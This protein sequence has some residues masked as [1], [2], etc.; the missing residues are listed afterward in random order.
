MSKG[1]VVPA[2]DLPWGA[3][4]GDH[5]H[6]LVFPDVWS[7]D[8]L[9][10]AGLAPCVPCAIDEALDAPFGSPTIEELS[11]QA[12][13]A[14]IVVDDLARPTP[15]SLILPAILRRLHNSGLGENDISI[16]IAT[17]SHG[18]LDADQIEQKVGNKIAARYRVTCHDCRGELASTGIQ[19]GDR[20]LLVNREFYLAD[21]KI[22][23]GSALPHPFAGYSGGAKL[24]IPGLVD[25]PAVARSHKFVQLGLRGGADP[26]RNRFRTEAEE[27]ARQLGL[28]FV[29]CAI[30]NE[31]REL[32]GITAGEPVAAHRNACDLAANAYRT[33][34]AT[35]YDCMVVNAYPKD[36][37]L[38]QSEGALLPL[39]S[40]VRDVVAERGVVILTTAA[41]A[42]IGRHGLFEPGGVN[43]QAPRKKGAFGDRELWIYA[44]SLSTDDVRQLYWEGY[45]VFHDQ[46]RLQA[47]CSD[48]F[49]RGTTVAILPAAPMQQLHMTKQ[50]KPLITTS[51][52]IS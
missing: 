16:V 1:G 47:A 42:G 41:S 11:G 38:V 33:E 43:F 45:P 28:A 29:V 32:V 27:L 36:I 50:S 5:T 25:L 22:A 30:T 48:R 19:Y 4:F 26:N 8:V 49:P 6:R 46:S 7:V 14:C 23:I 40:T 21:L 44:P 3:W 20:E 52:A 9:S 2:V 18:E 31:K 39:K 12:K 13:S 34:V 17:G 51:G 15:A 37:D 24:I 10:P 35:E